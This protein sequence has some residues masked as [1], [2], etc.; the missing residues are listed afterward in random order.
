[1]KSKSDGR[2]LM[3]YVKRLENEGIGLSGAIIVLQLDPDRYVISFEGETARLLDG[4]T[5]KKEIPL[6]YEIFAHRKDISTV[7][8]TCP[9]FCIEAAKRGKISARADD[10][11]QIV[12]PKARVRD[13][14]DSAKSLV[15]SKEQCLPDQSER[16]RRFGAIA[17]VERRNRPSLRR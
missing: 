10:M 13:E 15:F 7:M 11:A 12:G 6:I 2:S 16:S 3:E 8:R 4:I 1:M 5:L 9:R 17:V 14:S